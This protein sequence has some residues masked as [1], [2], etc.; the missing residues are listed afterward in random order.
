MIMMYLSDAR[1]LIDK[2]LEP[3]FVYHFKYHVKLWLSI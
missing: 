1:K 2:I 3:F